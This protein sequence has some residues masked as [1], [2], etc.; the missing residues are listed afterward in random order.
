MEKRQIG[1]W[2]DH[3]FAFLMA[4]ENDRVVENIIEL[5]V[6]Q[7]EAD[8]DSGK[9]EKLEYNKGQQLQSNYYKKLIAVIKTYQE[10]VLFGPTDAKNELLNLLKAE[11][12]LR[13]I[14]IEIRHSDKMTAIQMHDFVRTYFK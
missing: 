13:N 5:E 10:V 7:H 3:S 4:L 11:P 2:M 8:Y 14:K 12:L 1:I 9:N 6:S